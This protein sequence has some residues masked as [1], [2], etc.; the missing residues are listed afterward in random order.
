MR[1]SGQ[2]RWVTDGI[3][4]TDFNILAMNF[5]PVSYGTFAVTEPFSLLLAALAGL[6]LSCGPLFHVFLWF[7]LKTP[8][9]KSNCLSVGPSLLERVVIAQS[10]RPV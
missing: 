9:Q 1:Q 4:I 3:D 10:G 5:S 8:G 7:F 2:G 6:C